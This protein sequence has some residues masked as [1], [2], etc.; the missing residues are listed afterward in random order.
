MAT[1][2]KNR[3]YEGVVMPANS[4]ERIA[5][6]GRILKGKIQ[7]DWVLLDEAYRGP[8]EEL[9]ALLRHRDSVVACIIHQAAQRRADRERNDD[10]AD[11]A[12]VQ[13]SN[14]PPS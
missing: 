8:F 7:T 11:A 4:E 2:I 5:E 13:L 12:G 14:R 3:T 10:R 6:L 1:P 9:M